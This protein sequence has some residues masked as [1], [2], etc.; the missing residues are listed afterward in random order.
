MIS[1]Y[2]LMF[3]YEESRGPIFLGALVIIIIFASLSIR[4]HRYEA[5]EAPV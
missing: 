1:A 5:A 4:S 2:G 3:R